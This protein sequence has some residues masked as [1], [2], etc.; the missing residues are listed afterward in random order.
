MGWL[1]RGRVATGHNR[2]CWQGWV[3]DTVALTWQQQAF[4]TT[5]DD[6]EAVPSGIR[7]HACVMYHNDVY[8]VGGC[9][10]EVHAQQINEVVYRLHLPTL[11]WSTMTADR[12]G[13]WLETAFF[14]S[15][16]VTSVS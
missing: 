8:L 15:C 2:N 14:H 6:D 16:V 9:W 5:S 1:S 4:T 10:G 3:F 11:K 12:R 13:Q 7:S